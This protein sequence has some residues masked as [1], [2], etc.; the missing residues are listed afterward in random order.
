MV[1]RPRGNGYD[2]SYSLFT[3]HLTHCPHP[4]S[5]DQVGRGT[6]RADQIISEQAVFQL[7]MRRSILPSPPSP[8]P[9]R[10]RGERRRG[11]VVRV[12]S[13]GSNLPTLPTPPTLPSLPPLAP[14]SPFLGERGWGI[15][16]NYAG[17][18]RLTLI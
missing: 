2:Y 17:T 6:L 3:S 8:L 14:L 1:G 4:K 5:L 7:R 12:G 13:V 11:S 18:W 10:E 9:G 15:E 16:G